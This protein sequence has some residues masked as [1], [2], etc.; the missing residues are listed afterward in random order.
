[1]HCESPHYLVT[2]IILSTLLTSGIVWLCKL[3]FSICAFFSA[4]GMWSQSD[5][6]KEST[7]TQILWRMS[8]STTCSIRIPTGLM[9]WYVESLDF[10]W[11]FSVIHCFAP[12]TLFACLR[13]NY[14]F[15][16]LLICRNTV[17]MRISSP[18]PS[19]RQTCWRLRDTMVRSSCGTWSRVTS[20]VTCQPRYPGN[21]RTSHVCLFF[22][23]TFYESTSTCILK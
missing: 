21:M 20:S 17:T 8:T 22:F 13:F 2:I 15:W 4:S 10:W 6:T 3:Y 23:L 9:T 11:N 19:V 7:F 5:G 16:T 12:S 18:W 1:M 14:M